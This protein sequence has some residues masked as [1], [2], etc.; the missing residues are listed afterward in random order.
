[1]SEIKWIQVC[2][3]VFDNRKIKQI[4]VM[5]EGDAIIVIWFKLLCLAGKINESGYLVF[6]E[7]IPYTEQLLATEFNKPINI[8]QLALRTF[9]SFKMIEII[10]DVIKV[11]NWE[12]YQNVEG[13]ER[14]RE[15]GRNRQRNYRARRK[16]D[17]LECKEDDNDALCD[18]NVTS[19]YGNG[20]VTEQNKNKNKNK[21]NNNMAIDEELFERLWKLY[22]RKMGKGSV[23]KKSKEAISKIGEERMISAIKRFKDDMERQNRPT[24]M[25]PYGSTFF[26]SGYI[27]YLDDDNSQVVKHEEPPVDPY[28]GCE[29]YDPDDPNNRKRFE[30]GMGVDNGYW[31][32]RI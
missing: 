6:S 21:K 3:D 31:V 30:S 8:I 15:Q 32:Q 22:P 26:N 14:I 13:M 20:D 23:S 28:A 27:D 2:T 25:Y 18:S 5:P 7:E 10:D 29:K 1:M 19:R 12:R 9:E 24:D 16:Q 4:E 17:Q 11:S